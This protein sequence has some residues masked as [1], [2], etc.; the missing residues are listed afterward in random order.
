MNPPLLDK[1]RGTKVEDSSRG[2]VSVYKLTTSS[3]QA[4]PPGYFI[5]ESLYYKDIFTF[6]ATPGPK[7]FVIRRFGATTARAG[8]SYFSRCLLIKA[9]PV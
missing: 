6:S 1:E 9:F 3:K 2:E 5:T 4:L 7:L 8:G